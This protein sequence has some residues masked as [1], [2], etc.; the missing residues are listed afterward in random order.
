MEMRQQAY[1]QVQ[2]TVLVVIKIV[3]KGFILLTF[4]QDKSSKLFMIITF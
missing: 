1:Q 4:I 3:N 2:S